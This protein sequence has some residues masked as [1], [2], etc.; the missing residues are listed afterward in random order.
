MSSSGAAAECRTCHRDRQHGQAWSVSKL[1]H[2]VAAG[3][4]GIWVGDDEWAG[5]YEDIDVI[6]LWSSRNPA[7]RDKKRNQLAIWN[8]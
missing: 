4:H 7:T 2:A 3:L 5:V 1:Q 6:Q 8:D